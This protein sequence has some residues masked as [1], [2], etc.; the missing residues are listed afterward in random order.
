VVMSSE[1]VRRIYASGECE[2]DLARRELRVLG[3]PVPVGV[4]AFEII[5]VLAESAGE[6]V[7]KYE[8]MN[9]VWPGAIVTENTLQVH[10]VA[11]RKALG[12]YR[13]LL[14]TESRRGYRLLGSWTVRRQHEP[15]QPVGLQRARGSDESP[16]TNIPASATRLVGR[17]A[18]ARKL[19][20]LISAYRVVTL[21]GPGGIGKTTLAMKTARRILGGFA[22]GGWLVELASLSDPHLVPAAVVRAL[23]SKFESDINSAEAVAGAIGERKLLLILD[24]CEHVIDAAATLVDVLVRLCP[25]TTI[26][27]TSREVLRIQGECVYRVPPL[28]IP[29]TENLEAQQILAHSAPE[30]FI[31]RATEFGWDLASQAQ[32]LPA[33]AAICRHLDG[34]PLAIE[35]AAA[36]VATLGID[37][38]AGG[39]HDRFALL[40]S[41]RRTAISRHR[42]LRAT[43]DWSYH[44][45]TEVEQLLLRYL[46]VFPAG[47]T[48]EAAVAVMR[49]SGFGASTVM[50]GIAGLVTKSLVTLD[51]SD[52]SG[53]WYLLETIRAYASEKLAELDEIRTTTRKF[54]EFFRDLIT[55]FAPL[56]DF[57]P[58]PEALAQCFR[59]IDN[60][61]AALDWAF[62]PGGDVQIGAALA[63]AYVPVFLKYSLVAECRERTEQALKCLDRLETSN[64]GLRMQLLLGAGIAHIFTFEPIERCESILEIALAIA[65]RSGNL[66]AQI[67][68]LYGLWAVQLISRTVGRS[69]RV[70][71]ERILSLAGRIGDA[72]L[73]P[74]AHRAL[75]LSLLR[76]GYLSDARRHLEQVL[77]LD[78]RAS[79]EHEMWFL[80]NQHVLARA[81][82]ARTLLVQGF[83]DQAQFTAQAGLAEAMEGSG[84]QTLCIVLAGFVGPIAVL[85]GNHAVAGRAVTLL[86]D[87]AAQPG[88]SQY[89]RL[90][91]PLRALR[92]IALGE[93]PSGV[94][95]L[96]AELES[97][98]EVGKKG[99]HPCLFGPLAEGLAALGQ[100]TDALATVDEG[101]AIGEDTGERWDIP[102]L[103]RVKG[104]V[105]LRRGDGAFNAA[106]EDCFSEA[107]R[108]AREQGALFWEL[109]I[110]LSVARLRVRQ[111]RE[112]EVRRI[113]LPVYEQFTEGFA[114]P[115]VLVARAMLDA[116]SGYS[117]T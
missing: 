96:N 93:L 113:L 90:T 71:A 108:M 35:F 58:Q 41:G 115:D 63:A 95:L 97:N 16:I 91:R 75:G 84:K 68:A 102:E 114:T 20:D 53:R 62:S 81:M 105:L 29:A 13:S 73:L 83:V 24:N 27:A 94:A 67:R 74:V 112:G 52:P 80:Y 70:M 9:R 78:A 101:L 99:T 23:G 49:G 76:G 1:G 15:R 34:I 6:I 11:I 32:S 107:A 26:L 89:I 104:E 5:E 88:L 87:I 21:T 103:L 2:I 79:E 106:A 37:Q 12:P 46:A 19:R 28:E 77:E 82:L 36:R 7:T 55:G 25:N 109:R 61:R 17:A 54:A 22:D 85:T 40:T 92:L 33:I 48:F 8:L 3:S 69:A 14:K 4:R 45:L 44:L 47:F 59:E 86:E 30:L 65:E 39:L 72:A 57:R 18:A 10:A 56:S 51:R 100:I 42:T 117:G 50:D 64:A 31:T 43:L 111:G 116:L 66:D 110:A 98:R 60:T 38:V